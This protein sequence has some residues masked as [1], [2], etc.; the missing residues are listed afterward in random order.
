MNVDLAGLEGGAVKNDGG[1]NRIEAPDGLGRIDQEN[2]SF[3]L[4]DSRHLPQGHVDVRN[5]F[6]RVERNHSIESGIIE[7][8]IR[9]RHRAHPRNH[10]HVTGVR[11]QIYACCVDAE[12]AEGFHQMTFAAS[13]VENAVAWRR[14]NPV[15]DELEVAGVPPIDQRVPARVVASCHPSPFPG[16]WLYSPVDLNPVDLNLAEVNLV[17]LNLVDSSCGS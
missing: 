3:G 14:C 2:F 10:G 6:D 12:V 13:D 5:V 9:R 7:I 4:D 16:S 8:E 17:D 15:T 11:I 1:G